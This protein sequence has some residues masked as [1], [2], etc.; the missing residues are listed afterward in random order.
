VLGKR[1]LRKAMIG[2]IVPVIAMTQRKKNNQRGPTVGRVVIVKAINP[3]QPMINKN[4]AAGRKLATRGELFDVIQIILSQA[5]IKIKQ[6]SGHLT[7]HSPVL[8][9]KH[10]LH[11]SKFTF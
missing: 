3:P 1:L 7:S 10:W 11:F 9:T 8:W 2:S 6:V 4:I 5:I